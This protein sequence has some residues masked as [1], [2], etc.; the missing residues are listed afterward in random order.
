MTG[1]KRKGTLTVNRA[2][3]VLAIAFALFASTMP[4]EAQP[5]ETLHRIGFLSMGP[6][7]PK[8]PWLAAFRDGLRERGYVEGKSYV[9]EQ[10]HAARRRDRLPEAAAELVRFG[11]AVIVTHGTATTLAADRAARKSGKTVP[12]VFATAPDPVANRTVGSLARPGGN[13]T[14][15]SNTHGDLAPKRLEF[16]KGVDPSVT[17][18]AVIWNAADASH[19][20]QFKDLQVPASTL[21]VSLLP[22]AVRE[23]KDFV[24]VFA[25]LE[26]AR[27]DALN[28]FG[29]PLIGGQM[30]RIA[31]FALKH[32]LPAILT[33]K[34]FPRLG[35][36]MSYGTD[37]KDLYRRAAGY[38]D[39]ILKGAKPA[40]LPV[41]QP[42]KFELVVN[43]KTAKQIGVIF[44]NSI[45]LRADKVI[46]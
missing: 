20:R 9:I 31:A 22:F 11:V 46:E 6:V 12:V 43:L 5:A 36:L 34:R 40:D 1:G 4:A 24:G 39:K 23:P 21:G 19:A 26:E 30:R 33:I 17:R 38:V 15:L 16:L 8:H 27:P 45:L 10:R 14:G 37:F 18:I 42:T 2:T 35:G 44:P 28:I 7:S 41:E 3:S 13:I 32:R 29:D 25:S